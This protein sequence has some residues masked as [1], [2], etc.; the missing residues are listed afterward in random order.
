LKNN[1]MAVMLVGT[2]LWAVALIIL[3]IVRPAADHRWWIWTCLAGIGGGVFG[4][5]YVRRQNRS[6]PTSDGQRKD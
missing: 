1:D 2:G 5:W 3:L 6:R 4:L